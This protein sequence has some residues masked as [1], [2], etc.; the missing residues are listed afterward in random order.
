MFARPRSPLARVSRLIKRVDVRSD[1]LNNIEMAFIRRTL[2][3]A[4]VG[5]IK[6]DAAAGREIIQHTI[7]VPWE[8]D[9]GP[10]RCARVVASRGM[11]ATDTTGRSVNVPK[12]GVPI[13]FYRRRRAGYVRR[14]RTRGARDKTRALLRTHH[15]AGNAPLVPS[16]ESSTTVESRA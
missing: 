16:P 5:L 11:L 10:A 8:R 4:T 1:G 7:P 6:W 2:R 9:F 15:L 14:T 3:D 13:A 12:H